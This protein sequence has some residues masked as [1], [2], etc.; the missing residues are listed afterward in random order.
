MEIPSIKN[1]IKLSYY[2]RKQE[3]KEENDIQINVLKLF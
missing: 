2:K 1:K 3:G